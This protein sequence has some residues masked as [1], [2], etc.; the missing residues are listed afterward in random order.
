MPHLQTPTPIFT[1]RK[2]AIVFFGK[3]TERRAKELR[4]ANAAYFNRTRKQR[5]LKTVLVIE[6]QI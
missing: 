1:A 6:T 2:R 5:L 4:D 3:E